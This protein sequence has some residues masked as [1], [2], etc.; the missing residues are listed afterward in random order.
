MAAAEAPSATADVR[1]EQVT[2]RFGDVVAVNHLSLE[3]E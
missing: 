2:K 1:L 3:I